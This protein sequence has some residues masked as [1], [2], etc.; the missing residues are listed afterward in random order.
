[1]DR[2][3]VKKIIDDYDDTQENTLRSMLS[4]FYSRRMLSIAVLVWFWALVFIAGAIACAI[5][6]FGAEQT[7]DQIM[8]AALFTCMI[9]FVAFIKVFAWLMM[10]RNGIKREVK[11]LELRIRELAD[12]V[13]AK[14]SDA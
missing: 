1:M 13:T 11:R 4:E 6:F 3:Q 14:H 8:Y 10:A 5:G 12:N 9:L 7:K 2:E